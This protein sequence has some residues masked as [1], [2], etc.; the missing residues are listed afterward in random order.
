[1]KKVNDIHAIVNNRKGAPGF[2]LHL[3]EWLRLLVLSLTRIKAFLAGLFFHEPDPPL[4]NNILA[5]TTTRHQKINTKKQTNMK[6][7]NRYIKWGVT[8]LLVVF[9]KCAMA[10]S[11]G[12]YPL[13]GN[14][15]VCIGQTK[16]YG[17]TENPGS[18][19]A[20][21]ITPGT[22][23]TDWVLALTSASGNTI[24]VQWLTA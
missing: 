17:V 18:T 15:N 21:T 4:E 16:S 7:V 14:D 10:Q 12:P 6:P 11:G 1:M 9:A 13:T 8:L 20:W 23:G 5:E 24:T 19:Y 22:A 3:L 2:W